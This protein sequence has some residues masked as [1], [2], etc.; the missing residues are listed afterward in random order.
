MKPVPW[1]YVKSWNCIACGACCRGFDVVL[2]YKEW[3][4]IVRRFGIEATQP[5][6]TKLYLRKRIDGSCIFLSQLYGT[7]LC[8]LQRM[9]PRACKLWPFKIYTQPKYGKLAQALYSSNGRK[10]FIY[11]D[12][13]CKGIT[14]GNPTQDFIEGTLNEFIEIAL[15]LSE[16]QYYTTAK[17]ETPMFSQRSF[18]PRRRF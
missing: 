17:L 1:R 14:W 13:L 4:D 9:K 16:K 6:I 8:T 10:L 18:A 5:G 11:V 15:G 2:G 3:V 7:C 12:P